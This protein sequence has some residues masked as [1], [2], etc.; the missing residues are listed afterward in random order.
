M[1]FKDAESKKIINFK[2]VEHE[3]NKAYKEG[4][5]ELQEQ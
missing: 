5:K 1:A 3:N 2:L 4:V